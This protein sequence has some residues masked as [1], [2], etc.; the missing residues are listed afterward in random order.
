M[1][2]AKVLSCLIIKRSHTEAKKKRTRRCQSHH[3]QNMFNFE[4]CSRGDIEN[5]DLVPNQLN[6]TLWQLIV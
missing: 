4:N 2:E 5:L 6:R 3:R 1:Y